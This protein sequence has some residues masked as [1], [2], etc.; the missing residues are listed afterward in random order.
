MGSGSL[1]Q[2]CKHVGFVDINFKFSLLILT[3]IKEIMNQP[4][5]Y[6][7]YTWNLI[8]AFKSEHELKIYYRIII[9]KNIFRDDKSL[10]SYEKISL[11]FVVDIHN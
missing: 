9:D 3:R 5:E 11:L 7:S 1:W 10:L 4:P 6:R 8:H 2:P